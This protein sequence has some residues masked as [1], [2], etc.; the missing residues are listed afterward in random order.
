MKQLWAET[1]YLA[2]LRQQPIN[3]GGGAVIEIFIIFRKKKY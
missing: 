1:A 3:M 2:Q